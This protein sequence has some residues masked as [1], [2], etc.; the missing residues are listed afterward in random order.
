VIDEVNRA[1][2]GEEHSGFVASP[3]LITKENVPD[4]DVFD[5]DSGYRDVFTKVWGV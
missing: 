4:G 2:A 3:G 1:L 5:P